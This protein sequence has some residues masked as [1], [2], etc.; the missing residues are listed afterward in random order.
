MRQLLMLGILL[1][2]IPA[3]AQTR[4]L[5]G[6]G[7]GSSFG[8]LFMGVSGALEVPVKSR[9]ELDLG[10]IFSPL[11]QHIDLGVGW[12]NAASAG[13]IV[14]ITKAVGLGG[15]TTYSNYHVSINKASEYGFGGLTYRKVVQGMPI[16]F[17]FNYVRQ[18]NNGISSNGTETDHLQAGE[19]GLDMRVRC[20]GLV[21]FRLNFDYEVGR[22]LTQGNPVCDGTYGVTGGP[23]GG[24]C[25]RTGASSGTFTAGFFT[26]F[27]RRK[28]TEHEAF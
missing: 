5:V 23:N 26:E 12:A 13:G 17:T 18:L 19:F 2:A 22:V 11:E 6:T 14:W 9:F 4:V 15:G 28:N 7:G 16:R 24:P 27:P 21:C 3:K 25:P 1:F 20:A 8:N 10:D